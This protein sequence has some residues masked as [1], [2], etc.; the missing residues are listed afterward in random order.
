MNYDRLK[1]EKEFHDKRFANDERD[2]ESVGK[3]YSVANSAKETFYYM[4][5]ELC[6]D[7]K[8]IEFGCAD[9]LNL[10]IF[11]KFGANVTGID[12]SEEGIK[13]SSEKMETNKINANCL[14]MDVEK[15]K[16]NDNSFDIATGMGIIH[17]L[18]VKKVYAET[19]R[20]LNGNGHAIFF[21]PLGHN[22]L[23]NLFRKLTPKIRTKDEHPL[24]RK[25]LRM[26]KEYFNKVEIKYFSL[27]TL[28]AV[29]FRKWFF[30]NPLY[31]LL[32]NLDKFIF[33]MPYLKEWA[34]VAVIHAQ[35]P[36]NS[37]S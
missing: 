29:P 23:I 30:F 26:L 5:K 17:H 31:N 34:W 13:K 36:I 16:F 37:T 14:V 19:S 24:I 20:I 7:K 6:Y 33:K 1:A 22:P 12:I 10:E 2:R 35:N 3:F 15:T 32:Y 4:V 9:G 27:L 21:E 18:D 28:L 25:D 11:A 8:L